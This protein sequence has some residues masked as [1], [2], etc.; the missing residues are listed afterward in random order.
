[1]YKF[2]NQTTEVNNVDIDLRKEAEGLIKEFSIS[3]L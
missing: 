3:I 1:M 2:T